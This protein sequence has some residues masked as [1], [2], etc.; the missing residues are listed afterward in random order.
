MACPQ[1]R[2]K[3]LLIRRARAVVCPQIRDKALLIRRVCAVTCPV[4]KKG[5]CCGVPSDT[6]EGP[7]AGVE[8]MPPGSHRLPQQQ[9]DRLQPGEDLPGH[10]H[11]AGAQGKEEGDDD[12]DYADADGGDDYDDS[13]DD[14]GGW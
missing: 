3:A 9:G 11:F 6:G 14:G 7:A 4:D 13:D 5:A 8:G 10:H 12:H 1:I 2:E